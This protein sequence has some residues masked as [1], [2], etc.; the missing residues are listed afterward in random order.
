MS[1]ETCVFPLQ[2]MR[3]VIL[4]TTV[5]EGGPSKEYPVRPAELA[6]LQL[7]YRWVK[8]SLVLSF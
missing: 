1:V 6:C 7:S 3:V 2:S 4:L 8:D 5:D